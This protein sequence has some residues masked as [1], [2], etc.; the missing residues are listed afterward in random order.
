MLFSDFQLCVYH[1][2]FPFKKMIKEKSSIF[3]SV[4]SGRLQVMMGI[5]HL[6]FPCIC[7]SVCV[8]SFF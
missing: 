4:L 7:P 8:L 6:P 5:K 2:I 1:N 3:E